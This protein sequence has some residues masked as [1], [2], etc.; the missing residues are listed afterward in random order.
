VALA[1]VALATAAAAAVTALPA[2]PAQAAA[3]KVLVFSKTAG[4]RHDS[5]PN[6]IQAI[7]ELGNA[8]DF[9][10]DTTE[11]AGTFTTSNLAQ[12]KAV[13]WLSTTGDVLN[14][15]QQNA[16]QS[17]IDNGG[18]YVGIH[19]AADTEYDWAYYG[20]LMGAWFNNHPAIQQATV[21]TEDRANPAT[22]HLAATWSRSDEWYNYRTN[23]R[24]SVHVLQTLDETSYSGGNMGDHPITWCHPQS[25][26]RSFYTGLG[27]TQASYT[28]TNF[29]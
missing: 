6:G 27:H 14:T 3:Y 12:Y 18:G 2:L 5:I 29:R 10:V 16:F 17:Y 21:R 11:D 1:A 15:T 26:G 9:T 24:N 8:N 19:S 22:A 4:F 13:I 20:T 25:A 7:R 28:D 23:P